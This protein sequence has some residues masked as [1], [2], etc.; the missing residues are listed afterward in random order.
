MEMVEHK[1]RFDWLVEIA[2]AS[3]LAVAA[4]Y[5]GLKAAPLL[6]LPAPAAM[7]AS[8]FGFF[9]IGMLAMRAVQPDPH[10][11]P[12]PQIRIEPIGTAELLLDRE[13]Q[14]ELLLKTAVD[15]DVLLLEDVIH[16]DVLLLD[17]RLAAPGPDSRVVQLFASQPPPTPGQLR[18]RID[19]HLAG[20]PRSVP[21][22]SPQPPPDATDALFAALSELR[23]SLR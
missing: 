23:R 13:Y 1:A 12:L 4:G 2:G 17:D 11:H 7:T 6:A 18:D 19:R 20:A 21:A 8:G 5:A 3:A 10:G 15:D 22:D 16:D 9:A 14:D